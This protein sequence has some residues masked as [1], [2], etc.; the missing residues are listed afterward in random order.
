[1]NSW[2]ECCSYS[3]ILSPLTMI[4]LLL[5]DVSGVSQT[6]QN[7]VI[8]AIACLFFLMI[9]SYAPAAAGGSY[10]VRST[11]DVMSTM[12]F[13]ARHIDKSKFLFHAFWHAFWEAYQLFVNV[14]HECC[15]LPSP[16]FHYLVIGIS[17]QGQCI[18]TSTM[19]WVCINSIH[20][21]VV[22][23]LI[24]QY[25][26]CP[27]HFFCMSSS[28]A[29]HLFPFIQCAESHVFIAPPVNRRI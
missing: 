7:A 21:V 6:F 19:Q 24:I 3:P 28:L 26:S 29:S 23:P 13:A 25:S 9:F 27:F 4:K 1:M 10:S 15:T 18:C 5:I 8:P 16:H 11:V 20:R 12:S 2:I 17:W 22:C 14:L